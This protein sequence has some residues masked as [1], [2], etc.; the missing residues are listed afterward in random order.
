MVYRENVLSDLELR[1]INLGRRFEAREWEDSRKKQDELAAVAE[2]LLEDA[3]CV[4]LYYFDSLKDDKE[5]T[6]RT[7]ERVKFYEIPDYI[8]TLVKSIKGHSKKIKFKD[9][10]DPAY[11][12]GTPERLGIYLSAFV[13][14]IPSL[15]KFYYNPKRRFVDKLGPTNKGNFIRHLIKQTTTLDFPTDL[16]LLSYSE[17]IMKIIRSAQ[18]M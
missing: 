8:V 4:H 17:K 3:G 14:Y 7:L 13:H 16:V 12:N 1:A 5:K 15:K 2:D 18:K 10:H 11:A 9:L 6:Q